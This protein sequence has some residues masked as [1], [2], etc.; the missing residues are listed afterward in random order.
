MIENRYDLSAWVMH[1]VHNRDPA[2][3]PAYT[4]N[5]GGVTPLFPY[6][7][8]P[9]LNERFDPWEFFDNGYNI[10]PDASAFAVLMKI[11][12]NGH[13]RSGW[14]FRNGK[15][16]VYGPRAAVCLTE[17]PLY[18][19][20]EYAK[21]RAANAVGTYAVGILREELF[22]AGGRQ[23][24][25]GLSGS[26]K[27]QATAGETRWEGWPRKLDPSCGIAEFEQYRY[28]AMR[29]DGDRRIDWGHEREW[30][31]SDVKDEC[32]CPGLPI[33]LKDE[34]HH[35]SRVMI[36]VPTKDK[37][38]RVLDKL[39]ELHDARVHNYDYAY[40]LDVLRATY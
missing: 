26:H 39:K 8:D 20:I 35:F 24:I 5:E 32:S 4:L 31:W 13:I 15:P 38:R 6:H 14:S 30:R 23:A 33:W 1:F 34:P 17:M 12:E 11:L 19:L 7:E 36:V 10:E 21:R 3:D 18:A 25:Y 2:N 37:A 27:E 40:N 28:V 22:A 16:T 9:A 29:L